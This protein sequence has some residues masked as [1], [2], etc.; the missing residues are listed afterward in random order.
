MTLNDTL[1]VVHAT[2]AAP[3]PLNV[4]FYYTAQNNIVTAVAPGY[5]LY[6]APGSD[7]NVHIW[8]MNLS[9]ASKTTLPS[10]QQVS[11]LSIALP[12]GDAVHTVICPDS[13]TSL[14]PTGVTN[15]FQP[16][17]V[18]AVIHLPGTGGCGTTGDTYEVVNASDSTNVSPTV[19]TGITTLPAGSISDIYSSTGALTANVININGQLKAYPYT[20]GASPMS[21]SSSAILTGVNSATRL[22]TGATGAGLVLPSQYMDVTLSASPTSHEIYQLTK[23][24]ATPVYA[25]L[26][27]PTG[28]TLD[29]SNLYFIDTV[30]SGVDLTDY[31][32][33]LSLA[34]NAAKTLYTNHYTTTSGAA[35]QTIGSSGSVLMVAGVGTTGGLTTGSYYGLPIGVTTSTLA[36]SPP[37]TQGSQSPQWQLQL[38]TSGDLS[39]AVVLLD[40]QTAQ[41]ASA[42]TSYTAV[43]S[44]SA[45]PTV[46]RNSLANSALFFTSNFVGGAVLEVTGITDTSLSYLPG[47]INA[48]GG[49]TLNSLNLSTLALTPLTFGGN[50]AAFVFPA[51][52]PGALLL[53]YASPNFGAGNFN[54]AGMAYDQANATIGNYYLTNTYVSVFP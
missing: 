3:L 24:A 45:T 41:S 53:G 5:I 13:G 32:T 50:P 12:S 39:S 15:V 30:T 8:A 20:A 27:V 28:P 23:S 33:Q 17:T 26:G 49:G 25:A 9:T 54:Q 7:N 4:S 34:S 43:L 16:S 14:D 44:A 2:N 35:F 18:Y 38:V 51:L 6:A 48:V 31:V 40:W 11:N 10:A 1:T 19:L 29:A 36:A 47:T 22:A 37:Q 42:Y 52:T 21:G 46:L